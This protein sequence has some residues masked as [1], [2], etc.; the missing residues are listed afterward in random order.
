MLQERAGLLLVNLESS[1]YDFRRVVW[2]LIQGATAFVADAL[3]FRLKET[4]VVDIAAALADS[5]RR[6][7]FNYYPVGNHLQQDNVDFCYA[8]KCFRLLNSARVTVKDEA[9]SLRNLA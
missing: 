6:Q 2:T 5:P 7:A 9:F 8:L 3:H 4:Y 1:F